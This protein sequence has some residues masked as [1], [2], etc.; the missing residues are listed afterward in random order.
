MDLV[1]REKEKEKNLLHIEE[2]IEKKRDLLLDKQQKIKKM[3]LM[4]TLQMQRIACRIYL[5]Q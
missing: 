1:V 2:L 3:I 4:P 5:A